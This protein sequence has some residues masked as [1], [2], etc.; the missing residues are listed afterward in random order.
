MEQ[1]VGEISLITNGRQFM[2]INNDY[3]MPKCKQYGI[4]EYYNNIYIM[5]FI[6]RT[7]A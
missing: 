5:L 3:P 2:Y 6:S 4:N 1:P 7:C